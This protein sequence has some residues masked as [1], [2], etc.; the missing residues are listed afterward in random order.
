MNTLNFLDANV[1]LA[2][3]WSRHVHAER[4][5]SWFEEAGEQRFI[6]C[7]FTQFTG[8]RHPTTEKIM[9]VDTKSM[10]QAWSVWDR[11]WADDRVSFLAEPEAIE[12]EFRS[13]SRLSTRSPKIWADAYIL[14]FASVADLK[15]VTFD[16]ALRSHSADVLVL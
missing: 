11:I 10:S 8:L 15:L 5:R 1:W 3:V 16:R 4:A 9:G 2:L 7:R 13:R 14:A 6:F 12:K